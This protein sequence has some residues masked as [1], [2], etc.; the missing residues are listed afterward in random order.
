MI[1]NID[2]VI[3]KAMAQAEGDYGELKHLNHQQI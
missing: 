1:E 3:H 2:E